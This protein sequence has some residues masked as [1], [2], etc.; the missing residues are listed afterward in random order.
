MKKIVVL[1]LA[2]TLLMTACAAPTPAETVMSV[3]EQPA[4]VATETPAPSEE[5]APEVTATPA[6]AVAVDGPFTDILRSSDSFSF[7]CSPTEIIFSVRSLDP[8]ITSVLFF[9]RVVSKDS[10]IPAGA[11][12]N[13]KMMV[14]DDKG[15][16]TLPFKATD[17]KE[18][19]RFANGWF[20]YQFVGLSKSKA[21]VARSEKVVKQVTFTLACP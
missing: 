18:D 17:L 8:A 20:E 15:H 14:G 4:G 2:L 6:G 11:M 5:P 16:F 13:S 19:L 1:F 12:V 21:I 9:Y 3:T 7:K 10:G